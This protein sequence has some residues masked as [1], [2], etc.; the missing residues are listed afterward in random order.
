MPFSLCH[1]WPEVLPSALSVGLF[2]FYTCELW[3]LGRMQPSVVFGAIRAHDMEGR[4]TLW[5][6]PSWSCFLIWI[7]FHAKLSIIFFCLFRRQQEAGWLYRSDIVWQEEVYF[8]KWHHKT[9]GFASPSTPFSY[10]LSQT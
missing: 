2:G 9:M 5:L 1:L 8:P 6:L 7:Y 4:P 3:C 10:F